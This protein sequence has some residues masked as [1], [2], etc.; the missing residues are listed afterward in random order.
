MAD[1][2]LLA[3]LALAEL[4]GEL[5]DSLDDIDGA[6]PRFKRGVE[7]FWEHAFHETI[8]AGKWNDAEVWLKLNADD[9]APAFGYTQQYKLPSE[10]LRV[11]SVTNSSDADLSWRVVGRSIYI[12]TTGPI[13]VVAVRK[14]TVDE[15]SP[16]LVAAAALRLAARLA[17][18]LGASQTAHDGLNQRWRGAILHGLGVVTSQRSAAQGARASNILDAAGVSPTIGGRLTPKEQSL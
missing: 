6:S 14:I 7:R 11:F 15:A 5:V 3:D 4:Q 2:E 9:E 1:K 13:E 12:S 16:L 17:V 8:S 10:I 18:F